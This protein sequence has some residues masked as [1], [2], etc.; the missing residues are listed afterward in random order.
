MINCLNNYLSN[1]KSEHTSLSF[2]KK[3]VFKM[4]GEGHAFCPLPLPNLTPITSPSDISKFT[5]FKKV[6]K[7]SKV[8]IQKGKY[9]I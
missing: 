4:L 1:F 8:V 3:F 5:V 7:Y 2:P 9:R 6:Q